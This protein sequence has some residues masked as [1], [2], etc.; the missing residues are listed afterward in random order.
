MA[1]R[2]GHP[3]GRNTTCKHFRYAAV[4]LPYKY[5]PRKQVDLEDQPPAESSYGYHPRLIYHREIRASSSAIEYRDQTANGQPP[6]STAPTLAITVAY[7]RG[8]ALLSRLEIYLAIRLKN[9]FSLITF[10]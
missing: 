2:K 6:A 9:N 5:R 4:D 3:V 7:E 8:C 10:E 1:D